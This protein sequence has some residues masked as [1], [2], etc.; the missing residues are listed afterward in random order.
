MINTGAIEKWLL[1]FWWFQK[2]VLFLHSNEIYVSNRK[3]H[4]QRIP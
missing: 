2:I 4:H 3:Q 1:Y